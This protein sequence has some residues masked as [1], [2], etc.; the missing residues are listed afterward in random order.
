[1]DLKQN[2]GH[3]HELHIAQNQQKR[4]DKEKYIHCNRKEK[5]KSPVFRVEI[6]M[7]VGASTTSTRWNTR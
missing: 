7:A 5:S 6:L 2:K 4:H 3:E 1:M